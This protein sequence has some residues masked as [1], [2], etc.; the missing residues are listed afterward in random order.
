MHQ[1]LNSVD[2][3]QAGL[4]VSLIVSVWLS[5]GLLKLRGRLNTG[6]ARKINHAAILVGGVFWFTGTDDMHVRATSYVAIATLFVLLATACR[7][8]DTGLLRL[9]YVG[10]S[11]ESDRPHAAFHVWFS[12][13]VSMIGLLLV[14]IMFGSLTLTRIAALVLGI[15]DAV[16]EPIG[17]R[18]GVHRFSVT[19]IL[20]KTPRFR[21][22]EG[23]GS[24]GAATFLIVLATCSSL[25]PMGQLMPW[26]IATAV[27][28]A[29]VEA[30][31]P[32][33]FDNFTIPV[34]TA[35]V[36]QMIV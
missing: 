9:A 3:M 23:T 33:G 32:H 30:W 28:I 17:T 15:A 31:T 35:C 26:A 11:R 25:M 29:G 14:D 19:D 8:Q 18:F 1:L 16:A 10:Y 2:V 27:F 21:S 12:W 36:L 22:W 20:S 24:V 34:S 5:V 13:L 6:D 7:F 4:F